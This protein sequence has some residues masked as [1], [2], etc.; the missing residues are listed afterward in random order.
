MMDRSKAG[1]VFA[2]ASLLG[3]LMFAELVFA[4]ETNPQQGQ[5][6]IAPGALHY[7][8]PDSRR[9]GHDGFT[10]L[11][12]AV[13]Y[14]LTDDWSVEVMM[15]RGDS[16]W[17]NALGTGEDEIDF[18]S[19]NALYKFGDGSNGWQPFLLMGVARTEKGFNGA[20]S[21]SNDRHLSAGAG[22][23]GKLTER[24]SLRGDVRALSSSAGGGLEPSVFIGL[25]AFLGKVAPPPPPPDSD[26]DGVPN[27]QD[28]CPTT[29]AGRTVDATGC[30]LDSDGDGVVDF[31]DRCPNTPSGAPVDRQGCPLDSDG[32]GVPD[33]RDECPDS[34]QGAKV[35]E[36]GCY[37]ELEEAVTIDMNIEFDTN[38][39][40]IRPDQEGEIRRVVEFLRQYPT[41]NAVIEG[42]TDS[43]GSEGYNQ[44]LSERRAKAVYDYLINA[45]Q[46]DA[47]RLSYAGFGESRPIAS[48]DTAEGKQKNRRVS[49]VVTGSQMVRQR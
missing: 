11:G 32:D 1:V 39:A 18:Q 7:E 14:A 47:G 6:Y 9:H 4:E 21:D 49:A 22:V 36:K 28:Q 24:V 26:G 13:G 5:F 29:P 38:A 40:D 35:D 41:A 43:S 2:M 12:V 27:D 3:S 46:V 48:N 30:Q 42:H 37:I 20:R 23:F 45:A 31:E 10:S 19:L 25:T 16:E 8:A 34:E 15:G 44:A 17:S 33:F